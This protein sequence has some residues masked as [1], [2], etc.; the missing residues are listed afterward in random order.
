MF[1]QIRLTTVH[2]HQDNVPWVIKT[3]VFPDQRETPHE[4]LFAEWACTLQNGIPHHLFEVLWC[5]VET[6]LT[7]IERE[8]LLVLL[9]ENTRHR[10]VV[11]GNGKVVL[12][13]FVL[14]SIGQFVAPLLTLLHVTWSRGFP[15]KILV[16]S[17]SN[18]LLNKCEYTV[19][20]RCVCYAAGGIGNPT[21]LCWPEQ[22]WCVAFLGSECTWNLHVAS[23]LKG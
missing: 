20:W 12:N 3:Q 6:Y 5:A 4:H 19:K 11:Y 16:G 15:S 2:F 14:E 7:W 21:L 22:H 18:M 23:L 1:F 10:T 17:S 8:I 13:R 9:R